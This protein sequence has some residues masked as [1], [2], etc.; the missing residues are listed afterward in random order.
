MSNQHDWRT[1]KPFVL[2]RITRI[3]STHASEREGL[4]AAFDYM[5]KIDEAWD[6]ANSKA[7]KSRSNY[8]ICGDFDRLSN[9]E[10]I[11]YI[12]R[13]WS[14]LSVYKQGTKEWDDYLD[15]VRHQDPLTRKTHE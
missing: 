7:H 5:D 3:I 12:N 13:R 6:K 15:F 8:E 4:K 9:E 10:L 11:K 1:E 2:T 14:S